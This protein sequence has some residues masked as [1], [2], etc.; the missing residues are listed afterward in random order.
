MPSNVSSSRAIQL[1][2]ATTLSGAS[3]SDVSSG[4][5]Q[6]IQKMPSFGNN[7]VMGMKLG[8]TGVKMTLSP[9]LAYRDAK[10]EKEILGLQ[11]DLLDMQIQSIQT[12][13]DDVMRAGHQSSAAVS[14]QAGQAKSSARASMGAS[15]V[16]VN[17]AGSSAEA[18]SS[19]DIV[20]DMQRNQIV[21]NAVAQSWGYRRQTVNLQNQVLAI[22]SAKRNIT[23]WAAAVTTHLSDVMSSM[24]MVGDMFGNGK[25]G[26][27]NSETWQN[28]G[29]FISN[30]FSGG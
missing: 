11:A 6:I 28:A 18:L 15:G 1:E 5:G 10:I 22:E 8:Y 17:A 9:I 24:S 30:M 20:K 13:A 12:Q 25:G 7:F 23:P 16:R 21:A 26:A 2:S 29:S 4:I 3:K 14:Y 19:I 27:L